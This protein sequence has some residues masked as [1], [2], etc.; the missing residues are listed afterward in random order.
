MLQLHQ[1]QEE[2]EHYFLQYQALTEKPVAT[3]EFG[4]PVD[5]PVQTD[6]PSKPGRVSK[7]RL[8]RFFHATWYQRH[9]GKRTIPL[10]HYLRHGWKK[11]LSPHPLFDPQFYLESNG[12]QGL[13]YCPL[14]HFLDV[15]ARLGYS[16]HPLFDSQWYFAEY[17]DVKESGVN[18]LQHYLDCGASEGRNPSRRFHTDWYLDT[19]PDVRES[20]MNP[21][22]H[23][24]MFGKAD[25]RM[26][27][28]YDR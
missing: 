17:P 20:G 26:Q 12:L 25:E 22:L 14:I 21:L 5:M 6:K 27:G 4:I 10:S 18:P 7:Q 1:V 8:K 9:A 13:N 15:G 3:E 19:Y 11:Q 28:P 2:L 16:P 23:F 24:A